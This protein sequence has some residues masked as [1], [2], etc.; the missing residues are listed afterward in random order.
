MNPGPM[1][2][3]RRLKAVAL[4]VALVSC[5]CATTARAIDAIPFD[6]AIATSVGGEAWNPS[7]CEM[8]QGKLEAYYKAVWKKLCVLVKANKMTMAQAKAK[9]AAIRAAKG[10]PSQKT[11]TKRDLVV[12]A[13]K[14]KAAVKA[15]KLT[16]EQAMAKWKAVV[17]QLKT[18]KTGG[19]NLSIQERLAAAK[20]KLAAAVKARKLTEAQAKAKYAAYKKS[21]LAKKKGK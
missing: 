19:K 18:S 3:Y 21:L 14:L 15:G 13:K 20:K 7:T 4:S 9:M 10:N 16:K 11:L 5:T 17:K 1:D 6:V 2:L 8:G 12:I